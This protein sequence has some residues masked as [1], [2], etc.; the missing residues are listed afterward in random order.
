ME[1]IAH[2]LATIE[3]IVFL[4]I[5]M[6]VSM[7]KNKS[8]L[9]VAWVILICADIYYTYASDRMLGLV[10]GN[11]CGNTLGVVLLLDE[12]ISDGI[13]KK[14]FAAV[15]VR[16][17]HI[18]IAFLL[19]VLK[20]ASG[21][22][23]EENVEKT[24][25][26]TIGILIICFAG[27][28]MEKKIL[29]TSYIKQ[30]S[31][32][33]YCISAVF[34]LAVGFIFYYIKEVCKDVDTKI[35]WLLWLVILIIGIF[36][37]LFGFGFAVAML[38]GRLYKS[39]S[40]AKDKYLRLSK[41]YYEELSDNIKEVRRMKH[42][43]NAH[44]NAI[45]SFVMSENMESAKKYF[46]EI[47]T[48]YDMRKLKIIDVGNIFVSAILT[49]EWQHLDESENIII[50]CEGT[51]PEKLQVSDFVLCTIFSNL[52]AN[53]IEACKMLKS[54]KRVIKIRLKEYDNNLAVIFENPV[55][56]EVDADN[57]GMHTSKSDAGN[58]GYG[59]Y[60]VRNVVEHCNGEIHAEV[61]EDKFKISIFIPG[62]PDF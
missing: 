43:M 42:D 11:I 44:I 48:H 33:Y 3:T 62:K 38:R 31:K 26:A 40:E 32:E 29:L 22:A 56:W 58:H 28:L 51:L 61:T 49:E 34:G 12:D 53:S 59:L 17:L 10:L 7:H 4:H 8:R 20:K 37:Y 36:V 14:I 39:E 47:K 23:I 60:N 57:L 45:G 52:V 35:Q 50:D 27:R 5:I 19:F 30:I 46:A 16:F 21:L 18:P 15:Y 2:M 25:W 54:S 24:I 9:S 1:L 55:E 41:S 13:I 6:R